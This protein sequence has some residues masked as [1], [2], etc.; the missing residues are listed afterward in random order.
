M[1]EEVFGVVD[2][3]LEVASGSSL[4]EAPCLVLSVIEEVL[5]MTRNSRR[6]KMDGRQRYITVCSQDSHPQ[7]NPAIFW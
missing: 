6:P 5:M 3:L 1:L 2:L 7:Q 4:E